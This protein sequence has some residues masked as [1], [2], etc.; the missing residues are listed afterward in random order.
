MGKQGGLLEDVAD[1]SLVWRNVD[2][3]QTI[4]QR[5]AIATNP[6]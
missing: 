1:S 3:V 5:A 6:A 4:K 2:G